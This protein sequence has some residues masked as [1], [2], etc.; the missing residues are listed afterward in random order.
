MMDEP[1]ASHFPYA[2]RTAGRLQDAA[3]RM[4]VGAMANL[5]LLAA[6]GSLAA[7]TVASPAH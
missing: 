2:A 4:G 5:E 7:A 1:F 3:E 6:P